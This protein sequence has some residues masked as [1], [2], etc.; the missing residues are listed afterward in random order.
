MTHRRIVL[1]LAALLTLGACQLN[2]ARS[3][4]AKKKI[5]FLPGRASHGWGAHAHPATCLL[6]ARL[7]NETVPGV[8]AVVHEG[9]WPKDPA[10]LQG[11]AAIVIACD[12]NGIIGSHY[13]ELDALAKKGVGLAFL[14]YSVDVGN[15]ERGRYLI[16]WIGGY[17]EQYWSV[18]PTWKAEF[19]QLPEHAITRGVK[20]FAILD[21][22]YYHMRF[23]DGMAGVTPILT[24]IPP[25]STRKGKDGPHSGNPTVRERV[26]MPE[27]VAWACQRPDGG[28]GFGFTGGHFHWNWAN[29]DLRKL[30]LNAIVWVA[31]GEV[32]A[33]G[34]ATKTPT[35]EELEANQAAAKPD[36]W[37]REKTQQMID[38]ACGK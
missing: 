7:L 31:R 4:E 2:V 21:E 1:I 18:N 38:R 32:P 22:W 19:K 20:P 11:A 28:R 5:V 17:Y 3:A 9:G 8:E 24:A 34:V 36:N 14:H 15:K 25:D 29:D 26:G 23:R 33:A 30:V 10:V 6:L 16:D 35:A 37:T 13:D 12:G 27:H